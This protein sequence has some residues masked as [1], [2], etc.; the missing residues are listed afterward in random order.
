MPDL[1]F[2]VESAGV[3]PFAAAPLLGFHVRVTNSGAE[4]VHS[5]GLRCQIQIEATRRLYS[6]EEQASLRDLFGEPQRWAQT[7][8]TMLWTH[9][10]VIVPEFTGST[11]VDLQVPCTFDFNIAVVK[12]FY[13]LQAGEIPLCLQFSGSVFYEDA[14]GR[15]QV[16]PIP[17]N[18]EA[19]SRLPLKTW[20]ELIDL[21]YPNSAWLYL[22]RDIFDRLYKYK[23][24]RGI[25]TWEQ[26]LEGLLACVEEEVRR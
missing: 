25:P 2:Q 5:I 18:K 11:L 22:R 4:R 8:H 21:H 13:G 14:G 15:L 12:Y 1:T 7:L 20:N 10:N 6:P 16:A 19:Q 9:A 24:R 17:W 3:V 23:V 26:T